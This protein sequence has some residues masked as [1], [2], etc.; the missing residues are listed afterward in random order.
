MKVRTDGD[1]RDSREIPARFIADG[2]SRAILRARIVL[3]RQ[4]GAYEALTAPHKRPRTPDGPPDPATD[5]ATRATRTDPKRD[6]YG[7]GALSTRS[8][9][10]R[11]QHAHPSA[12]KRAAPPRAYRS[13]HPTLPQEDLHLF[14][15]IY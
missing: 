7:T 14:T 12:M 9:V 5:G 1:A 8:A 2:S 10:P 15:V 11:S 4:R 3:E 6:S 13:T